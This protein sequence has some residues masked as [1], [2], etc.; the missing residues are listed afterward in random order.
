MKEVGEVR[1]IDKKDSAGFEPATSRCLGQLSNPTELTVQRLERSHK[2][3]YQTHSLFVNLRKSGLDELS[4]SID[5]E[6]NI[7]FTVLLLGGE[8]KT[9][10]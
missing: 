5:S 2:S 1:R 9:G 7:D 3:E 4:D 8:H 6:W 10:G